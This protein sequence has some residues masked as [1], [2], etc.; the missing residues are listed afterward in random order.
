[1]AIRGAGWEDLDAV[2]EL[3]G[4]QNR[5]ASGIA[6]IRAEHLRSEWEQ[7]GFT[8]GVDNL[9]ADEGGRLVGY[10]AVTP[11]R[12][13]ILAAGD[14]EVA[15]ELLAGAACGRAGAATRRSR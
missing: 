14:D 4:A 12:E 15:D 10:A 6:G 7:P 8:L 13:L 11:R 3:L 5:A 9:V 1:M 2:V